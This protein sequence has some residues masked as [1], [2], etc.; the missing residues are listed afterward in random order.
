LSRDRKKGKASQKPKTKTQF[1]LRSKDSFEWALQEQVKENTVQKKGVFGGD[2][3]K[4]RQ[5]MTDMEIG[6]AGVMGRGEGTEEY[7][8]RDLHHQTSGCDTI[9]SQQ[10]QQQEQ[11]EGPQCARQQGE[12]AH[13]PKLKRN[14]MFCAP[15]AHKSPPSPTIDI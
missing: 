10:Q 6:S 13:V 5:K 3:R 8:S 15:F 4:R 9:S 1:Q 7:P 2:R 14:G 11:H 12:S